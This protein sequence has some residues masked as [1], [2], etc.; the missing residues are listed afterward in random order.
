MIWII[1]HVYLHRRRLRLRLQL[2]LPPLQEGERLLVRVQLHVVVSWNNYYLATLSKIQEQGCQVFFSKENGGDI[3]CNEKA[4]Y[5]TFKSKLKVFPFPLLNCLA[6]HFPSLHETSSNIPPPTNGNKFIH[7]PLKWT[8]NLRL[9]FQI[10]LMLNFC[11]ILELLLCAKHH[12]HH[13][14]LA[15]V[16]PLASSVESLIHL[17][18]P[19]FRLAPSLILILDT[20]RFL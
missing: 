14:P 9:S 17:L 7:M 20:N 12:P 8:S 13:H 1:D 10:H 18:S 5:L 4:T 6:L 19:L 3:L 2:C 16:P 11:E 15:W